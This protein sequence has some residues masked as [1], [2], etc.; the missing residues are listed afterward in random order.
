MVNVGHG[1]SLVSQ[2]AGYGIIIGLG[3]LLAAVILVAVK[4]QKLYLME[5]SGRSE[6]FMVANRSVGT[7]LTCSAVFPHGCGS[8]KPSLPPWY[9][10]STVLRRR[11]GSAQDSPFKWP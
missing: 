1:V 4:I 10:T 8:T 7:G 11:C 6:M 9:A 2:G 3:V 5:D